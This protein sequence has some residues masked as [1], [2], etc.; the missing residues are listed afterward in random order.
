M[1]S[2]ET[3][4]TARYDAADRFEIFLSIA[5]NAWTP[6]AENDFFL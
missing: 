5:R 3:R 1:T 4:D 6:D 2:I